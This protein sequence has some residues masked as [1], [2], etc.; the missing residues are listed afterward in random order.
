MQDSFWVNRTICDVLEEMRKCYDSRNF[1]SLMGLIE[2]AQSMAN[3]MESGL[4]DKN[5][6]KEINE[7]WH[8]A[9]EKLKKLRKEI[10]EEEPNE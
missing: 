9:K 7:E 3:R 10:K 1:A 4:N 6:I 8:K 5:D 2:E